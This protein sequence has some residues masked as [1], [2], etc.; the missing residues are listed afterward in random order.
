MRVEVAQNI[1]FVPL[2]KLTSTSFSLLPTGRNV[3]VMAMLEQ[4]SWT[5][6]WKL[7]VEDGRAIRQKRVWVPDTIKPP[8]KSAFI[9]IDVREE[10]KLFSC[11]V[12]ICYLSHS[13]SIEPV[14]HQCIC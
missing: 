10:S 5:M 6:R 2:K 14:S 11:L 8:S 12:D 9:Q 4:P 13:Y 7:L 3:D 1:W